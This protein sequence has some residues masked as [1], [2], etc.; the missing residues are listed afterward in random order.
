MAVTYVSETN[1]QD[2]GG[3][4]SSLAI[5]VPSGAQVDDLLISFVHSNN[6]KGLALPSGWTQLVRL[7]SYS[8]FDLLVAYRVMQSGDTTWSWTQTTADLIAGKMVAVRG[9]QL[10]HGLLSASAAQDAA[11]TSISVGSSVTVPNDGMTLV[12]CALDASTGGGYSWSAVTSGFTA[13]TAINRSY[14]IMQAFRKAGSGSAET[15]QMQ[16]SSA[17]SGRPMGIVTVGILPK[18]APGLFAGRS[19]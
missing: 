4:A 7:N 14:R 2:A 6:T 3:P 12:G 18:R 15:Q 5:A 9:G 8:F 11:T 1:A 17:V 10:N 16:I 13:H 19:F